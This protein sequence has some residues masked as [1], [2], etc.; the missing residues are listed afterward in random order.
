MQL[1][2]TTSTHGFFD[3]VAG[4]GRSQAASMVLQPGQSTGSPEN[5][6]AGSDQWL[7]VVSGTGRA[8]IE[9]DRHD[10]RAG[11]LVLIEPG[12]TH[13]IVN[14]GDDPL[15]TVNVYAPPEY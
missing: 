4:T 14:T 10:L 15:V 8:T 9:G 1:V 7:F 13:E 11:T 3:V 12:E 6:H 2:D 5:A